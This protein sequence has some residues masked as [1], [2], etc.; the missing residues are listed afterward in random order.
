M[1]YRVEVF[2]TTF[3][4]MQE[5]MTFRTKFAYDAYIEAVEADVDF[6]DG[7][8]DYHVTVVKDH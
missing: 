7:M 6:Q 5:E 4:K 8:I 1:S 3:G 2:D